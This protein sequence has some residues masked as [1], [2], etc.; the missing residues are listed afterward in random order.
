MD[1]VF[2]TKDIQVDSTY[3]A[4]WISGSEDFYK[5]SVKTVDPKDSVERVLPDVAS[6]TSAGPVQPTEQAYI[7]SNYDDASRT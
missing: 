4:D 1:S 2:L 6:F 3:G 5:V 7:D